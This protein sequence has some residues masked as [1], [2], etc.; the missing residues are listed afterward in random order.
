M[1]DFIRQTLRISVAQIC[2]NIGWHSITDSSMQIMTDILHRYISDLAISSKKYAEHAYSNVPDIEDVEKALRQK[3]VSLA[4]LRNYVKS[5]GPVKFPHNLPKLNIPGKNVLNPLKPGSREVVTRP[6]HI[7]EHLPTLYAEPVEEEENTTDSEEI[8]N[9]TMNDKQEPEDVI[10]HKRLR[11]ISSVVMTSGG[12]LSPSREGRLAESKLLPFPEIKNDKPLETSKLTGNLPNIKNEP[13]S[14][15]SLKKN[16]IKSKKIKS[17]TKKKQK[18]S[19]DEN[20]LLLSKEIKTEVL[21]KEKNS[22]EEEMLIPIEPIIEPKIE[23]I[24]NELDVVDVIEEIPKKGISAHLTNKAKMEEVLPKF[25]FFGSLP[26]GPGLIPSTFS[27]IVN[28]PDID[29]TPK[30]TSPVLKGDND[31]SRKEQ[32]KKKKDKKK[33][34]KEKKKQKE[35]EKETTKEK[36]KQKSKCTNK[37]PKIKLK[38]GTRM[39]TI[40]NLLPDKPSEE[41][42]TIVSKPEPMEIE[43]DIE[44]KS[45]ISLDVL[46]DDIKSPPKVPISKSKTKLN[47]KTIQPVVTPVVETPPPPPF[48]F[49]EAGNQVWICPMCT[50]PDDG[51]PMIGCDGCD[52]WYHWV[53]VGI[54]CP[55]DC[56]VWYCPKCLEKRAQQP[57]GK[58]G[59]PRKNKF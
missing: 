29:K 44:S 3:S 41:I 31:V 38:L 30:P 49:D 6:I 23:P 34:K 51:S 40:T 26:Q 58:R 35:K 18:V 4:E 13:S 39:E 22:K 5:T 42:I 2:D 8:Q 21:S 16:K 1:E 46:C 12:F 20:L 9:S 24:M 50:K 55:P 27:Q 56:A 15:V 7:H 45:D 47:T 48:Y 10:L 37:V 36:K 54:Q 33:G 57:K 43:V 17:G 28:T 19:K 14:K 59:R 32:K 25:S 11:E 52:V 53:C